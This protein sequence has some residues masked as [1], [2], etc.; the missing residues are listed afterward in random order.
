VL[1]AEG[2]VLLAF[3]LF[4]SFNARVATV[5]G[6]GKLVAILVPLYKNSSKLTLP[7]LILSLIVKSRIVLYYT[8]PCAC[9]AACS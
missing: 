6:S 8:S 1:A 9:L 5:L 7:S 2:F 4:A 3:M